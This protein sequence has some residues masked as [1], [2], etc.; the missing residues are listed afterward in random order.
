MISLQDAIS[1]AKPINGVVVKV[2][3]FNK[4]VPSFV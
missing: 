4:S 3:Y 2:I 1:K